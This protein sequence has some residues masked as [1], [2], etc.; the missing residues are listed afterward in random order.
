MFYIN[1]SY[2]AFSDIS[3]DVFVYAFYSNVLIV[4]AYTFFSSF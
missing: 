3:I 4:Y 1:L 2:T